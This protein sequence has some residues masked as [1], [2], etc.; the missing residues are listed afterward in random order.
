MPAHGER[1]GLGRVPG[2]GLGFTGFRVFSAFRVF[3][4]RVFSAFRVFGFRV[5]RA[6]RVSGF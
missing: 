5:F 6:F 4:F 3:G 2:S 1:P